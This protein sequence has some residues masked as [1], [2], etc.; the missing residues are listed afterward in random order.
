MPRS[1]TRSCA[2]RKPV[3]RSTWHEGKGESSLRSFF[4]QRSQRTTRFRSLFSPM[5]LAM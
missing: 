5:T 1:W 2:R 3:R 4:L